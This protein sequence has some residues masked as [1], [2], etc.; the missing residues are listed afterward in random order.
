MLATGFDPGTN[1]APGDANLDGQVDVFDMVAITSEGA[2]GNGI[3]TGWAGGDFNGDAVAN[4]FDL[5]MVA[6]GGLY[7]K[8]R[9]VVGTQP[10][11]AT[12][13]D[14]AMG[15]AIAAGWLLAAPAAAAATPSDFSGSPLQ[16]LVTPDFDQAVPSSDWWS[17]V[18]MPVFGDQF[19]AP[20]H[21]HP[22]TVQMTADGV[23][24]GG[25]TQTTVTVTGSTT[26]EYKTPHRFDLRIDLLGSEPAA[27]FAVEQY[28]DWSFTGRWLGGGVHPTA[29]LVQG[30]PVLWLDEVDFSRAVLVPQAGD[31]AIEADA[32][33]AFVTIAGRTSLVMAPE[34]TWLEQ[35]SGGLVV[36]GASSGSLVISLLPDAAAATREVFLAA[37]G[38]QIQE[39]RFS[40]NTVADPYEVR[41][42]YDLGSPGAE[43]TET[44]V[45]AYPHLT[46]LAAADGDLGTAA[47]TSGYRSPRGEMQLFVTTGLDVRL[48]KRGVLPTLP[49][50]LSAEQLATLAQL[51]RDDPAAID[52]VT[53][54]AN[55]HDTYWS[56][57]AM[58]K[59]AQLAQLA[60]ITG[61]PDIRTRIVNAV[62]AALDDWF[63]AS[64]QPGDKH[65]AYNAEWDTIQGY[66]DSFGSAGDLNDHHFHYGYFIHAAALVGG[67]DPAWAATRRTMIDLLVADVA[68]TETAGS[69]LP[70]L[71][72]F[73][74]LAGHSWASGHGAFGSG[75]NHE[76]SSEAMNF[77]TAVIL[78]GEVSGDAGMTGL[79]QM[80][81]SLEAE[82]IAEYWF[83][84]YGT[85]FPEGF[86]HESLG[87]VWG[88]GGSHATWFSAEPEM[89]KGINFLP[90][91]GGS[92][93]L[94]EMARDP[95]AL[96]AEISGLGGGVIDDWPGI[97]LQYEA[98]VDPAAAATRLAAGGI[99]TEAGQTAAQT[100]FWTSVLA[101][102]GTP[103]SEIRGD[104]PLS[105]VFRRGETITYVAHNAGGDAITV[106]FN[107]E[108][109]FEVPAGQTVTW[110]RQPGG[111]ELVSPP[112]F[113]PPSAPGPSLEL[114]AATT[115][116]SLLVDPNTE[117]AYL[118]EAGGEPILIRR[119][120]GYWDG[121][122]PLS[123]G[124]ASLVAAARDDLGRL[125]VLDVGEWGAF[126]WILDEAGRF[127]GEEGPADSSL[128]SKEV[129]F[130]ID[131]DGDGLAGTA[132]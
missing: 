70:R 42:R 3:A 87:M 83:D 112:A 110:Q 95:A 24:F 93:Y 127:I 1:P 39:T 25:P 23:L 5:V 96:L 100:Y 32:S 15:D 104:H 92:L 131:L 55:E 85:V 121:E 57:K 4:V 58:L 17:S 31:A 28:G 10:L 79:G 116:V 97:I 118:Q 56:G 88:D 7:G 78:W 71:R 61:Q 89:I 122:V 9:Y 120:D 53:T 113:V 124:G 91:H 18:V 62:Q 14:G 66:P 69:L 73:S 40:W 72:T 48:P 30:S 22:L 27:R 29:T 49:A 65:F 51:V 106:R 59:L 123:R 105:A 46:R 90:F 43:P 54:L 63:T 98:L 19:S 16:P 52:P 76:S 94:A 77:A 45:A 13:V 60:D 114:V 99:G 102:I 84:R 115:E 119:A 125:R 6:S 108:T 68:G 75:N 64:G 82:A 50:V 74:P 117:L 111:T 21:V 36:R 12:A 130:N 38:N 80:L 86:G 33:H 8:G 37:A 41:L 34:G 44:L 81:Y 26:T 35:Q 20:L 101:T 103:T 67:Y 128:L 132:R 109:W 129:L 11:P 107:D 2:Y 126:A 47:A